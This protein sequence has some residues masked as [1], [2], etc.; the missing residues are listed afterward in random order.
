MP[1]PRPDQLKNIDA[2]TRTY[3]DAKIAEMN[4][5]IQNQLFTLTQALNTSDKS[6]ELAS[7][8]TNARITR[9]ENEQH[10]ATQH[11][12]KRG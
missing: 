3:I 8:N 12:R 2:Q 9:L 4:L 10:T 1:T 5:N 6:L 11:G 7:S